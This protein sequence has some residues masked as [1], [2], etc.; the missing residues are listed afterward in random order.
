MDQHTAQTLNRINRDFYHHCAEDF[1]ATR[2]NPWKGWERLVEHIRSRGARP[3]ELDVL[4]VGCGNGRFAHYLGE[5][6]VQFSYLGID[7]ST[8]ALD[9]ARSRIPEGISAALVQHDLLAEEILPRAA[10]R[11]F[12]LIVAFGLLHHVP[13]YGRRLAILEEL[14]Q[15]LDYQGILA[16]SI[17]Q[18]GR[19]DRFKN[20]IVSWD[21]LASQTGVVIDTTQ[22]EPGDHILS[23]GADPPSYRYCHFIDA[24]EAG[25]LSSSLPLEHLDVYSADGFSNS[26]N[27][28]YLFRRSTR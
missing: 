6:A 23:W 19:F 26:L 16:V 24:S 5:T 3:R 8:R 7:N 11:P 4:D 1:S 9:H 15:R 14:A 18:F 27:Q 21:E 13:S 22:L 12:S 17:W 20:K 10:H 2:Q 25:R 28:Y